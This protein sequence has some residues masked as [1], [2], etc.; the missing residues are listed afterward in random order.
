MDDRV[1]RRAPWVPWAVTS[2]V[3]LAVACAAYV[4]GAHTAGEVAGADDGRRAWMFFPF[5][6]IWFFF[7]MFWIFGG[8]RWMLW[9]AWGRPW[10]HRRYY[11]PRWRDDDREDWEEWHRRAHERMGTPPG[12]S[13]A[14][15]DST[16][17][18]V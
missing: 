17:R 3:L 1:D 6:G 15:P 11:Y 7:V 13:A 18:P 12:S 2:V 5:G 10:R 4:A 9:G 8:L 14:R 16:Q